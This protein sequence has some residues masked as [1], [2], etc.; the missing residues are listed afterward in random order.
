MRTAGLADRV[1]SF[2]AHTTVDCRNAYDLSEWWKALLDYRDDLMAERTALVNRVHAE[3]TGLA[4]GYQ[5]QIRSLTSRTRV[6]AA[7]ELLTGEE[8]I[9]AELC[10]RRLERVLDIDAEAAAVKRAVEEGFK[11]NLERR[12]QLADGTPDIVHDLHFVLI[13]RHLRIRGYYDSDESARL[14]DLVR[15]ARRLAGEK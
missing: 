7:V 1:T 11:L 10:R 6:K 3:L 2:I 4:P 13:D 8:G 9:R 12:G 5:A 14:D 15:D